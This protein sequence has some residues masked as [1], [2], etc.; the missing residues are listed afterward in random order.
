MKALLTIFRYTWATAWYAFAVVVVLLAALFSATRLLLPH[1]HEYRG[2]LEAELSSYLQQP[3][4]IGGLD[5]QWHGVTPDLVLKEVRLLSP[6]DDRAVQQLR[7]VRLTLDLPRSLLGWQPVFRRI[8]LVGLQLAVARAADGSLSLQGMGS[9]ESGSQ[10]GMSQ[11]AQW[12]FAQGELSLEKSEITWRDFARPNLPPLHLQAM[13]AVLSND[14][15]RHWL[16]VALT[17]PRAVGRSLKLSMLIEGDPLRPAD[18]RRT[19]LYLAGERVDLGQLLPVRELAGINL[20]SGVADFQLWGRWTKGGLQSLQGEVGVRQLLL[21]REDVRRRLDRLEGRFL[22][23]RD[24]EGWSLDADHLVL[25]DS[26]DFWLPSRIHLR[27]TAEDSLLQASFLRLETVAG[28]LPLFQPQLEQVLPPEQRERL[29][30][31]LQQLAPRGQVYDLRLA[32]QAGAA[33]QLYGRFENLSLRAWQRVPEIAGADGRLWFSPQR[34]VLAVQRGSLQLQ[35]DDLFR[36][37]LPVEYLSGLIAWTHSADAWQ[38]IGRDLRLGNADIRARLRLDLS[39]RAGDSSPYISLLG[40]FEEGNGRSVS[41]YL[42]VG[43]MNPHTVDWLD[44][45]I[46]DGRVANGG[47]LL[48][49]RLADFP[50]PRGEGRFEVRFDLLDGRLDYAKGWPPISDI[51]AEVAFVGRSLRLDARGGR[52]LHSP[53]RWARAAIADLHDPALLLTVKGEVAG[54]TQDKLDY[55][56]QSPPL[57]RRFGRY[58]ADLQA[59]GDSLLNL[60]LQLPLHEL[61]QTRVQGAVQLEDNRLQVASVGEILTKLNGYLQFSDKGL[62]AEDLSAALLGQPV[63]IGI[64]PDGR[65]HLAVTAR[66]EF[67][68]RATAARYLPAIKDLLD[69]RSPLEVVLNIPQGEKGGELVLHAF[70]PLRGITSRLPAPLDKPAKDEIPLRLQIRF[71]AD[72]APLLRLAYGGVLNGVFAL[73]GGKDEYLLQRGELRL[74]PEPARLPKQPGLRVVGWLD[75]FSID[76]WRSVLGLGLGK[77]T[78][79]DVA[80]LRE[81]DLAVR[82]AEIYGQTLHNLKL[83]AHP[84]PDLWRVDV[85]SLELRGKL[86]IPRTDSGG[87]LQADLDYCHLNTLNTGA[88]KAADPRQ[89]PPLRLAVDDLR[90]GRLQLGGLQLESVPVHDG[91]KIERLHL[92]PRDTRIDI[93]GG[94]FVIGGAQRS[95]IQMQLKSDNVQHTLQAFNYANSIAGGKGKLDLSLS[96]PGAPMQLLDNLE[97]ARGKLSLDIRDGQLLEVSPGAGR[98]FGL[99]SL[100]TLP[101]RLSLDFSDLF[102]KGFGFDRI[103]GT[104]SIDNGDAYTSNLYMDGP[105]AR[106]EITGRTGLVTRDYDQLV[107]VTPHISQSLPLLGALAVTP[108]VGAAILFLQKVLEPQINK[109]TQKEY[110][111]TGPWDAPNIKLVKKPQIDLGETDSP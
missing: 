36:A 65:G 17:L 6:A 89:L 5:A 101:R 96:W 82:V 12:L 46:K 9:D 34:V 81:A 104:F 73:G 40:H 30:A 58:L 28:L 54:A 79:T 74:S 60:D 51:Q 100:Q 53:I 39:R 11:L 21:S 64:A 4:H 97:Q 78:G 32:Q 18:Q 10:A 22:W 91:L 42:P 109:A 83:S 45:A 94:W 72:S 47:L 68:A 31:P 98:L 3:V 2:E 69:G 13:N 106:V 44:H 93:A 19:Q 90:Y 27:H 108:Q 61:A 70:T 92:T 71:P 15:Q 105:A 23:Q 110:T 95:S 85:D 87:V 107:L 49:G 63:K 57:H 55:L 16:D 24:A 111:V 35:R 59:S 62:R 37:P 1:A 52:I 76:N 8:T 38:L 33:V 99:L 29:L 20:E 77:A 50:Y 80:W 14:G 56:V 75:R 67:E 66:G 86:Q 41:R 7:S 103:Q 26:S 48:H 43:V 84:Q 25:R 88:G 102:R